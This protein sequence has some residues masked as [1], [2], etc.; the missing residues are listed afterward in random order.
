[1]KGRPDNQIENLRARSTISKSIYRFALFN[2]ILLIVFLASCKKS[3][4]TPDAEDLTRPVIWLDSFEVF[5]TASE[6]GGNPPSQLFH[7]KNSGQKTLNY[8]ITGNSEWLSIEPSNGSSTGHLVEHKIS[9]NK[10]GLVGQEASYSATITLA[11]PE[12]YNNPQKVSVNLKMTKEPSPEISLSATEVKFNTKVGLNPPS[13]NLRIRNSGKGNLDYAIDC[14]SNWLIVSPNNG[15]S[16]GQENLHTIAVNTEGLAE[17]THSGTIA[18][19]DP[20]ASNSP[21]RVR[22]T[23]NLGQ[24]LSPGIGVSPNSLTFNAIS[25][26]E[27]PPPQPLGI[28]NIGGGTLNYGITWG[29]SWLSVSP[30]SGSS[31]GPQNTHAVSVNPG[32]LGVGIYN[33]II[34]IT[35][36]KASNSPQQTSVGLVLTTLPTDNEISISCAPNSGGTDTMVTIPVSIKGNLNDLSVFGLDLTFDSNL[37][38]YQS[39]GKGNLTGDW[40]AVDGNV[41]SPGTLRIGGF[42]GSGSTVLSGSIGTIVVITLKVTGSGYNDGQQSQISIS[43]YADDIAGM[44]P[45]PSSTL[46]TFRK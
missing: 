34:T 23:L 43:S 3:P 36:P 37:F 33:A 35:D 30:A 1:M 10:T 28:R 42:A 41:T 32:G 24:V 40:A 14:D 26:R 27:N 16:N 12:A 20:N 21:Q 11:C 17:G 31:S 9:V 15:T 18:I 45:E 19:I 46:F 44:K 13:Q 38:Q 22:V 39:T 4:I 7:V 29:A 25:G 2:S 8:T 6:S 5:F